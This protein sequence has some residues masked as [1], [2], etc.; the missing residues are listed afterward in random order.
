M[1]Y[2][3]AQIG[4]AKKLF[5]WL[6]D[7]DPVVRVCE[8]ARGAGALDAP[9][10][11][12]GGEIVTPEDGERFLEAAYDRFIMRGLDLRWV[13]MGRCGLDQLDILGIES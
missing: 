11:D 1:Q 9:I 4:D 8:I 3:I 5:M 2:V 12:W 10:R 6:P 13:N 7:H